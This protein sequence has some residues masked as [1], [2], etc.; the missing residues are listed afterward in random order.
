MQRDIHHKWFLPHSPETV[1]QFL[2]ESELLGQWLMKNDFRPVVG[3]QFNFHT[4]P[5]PGF[6]GTVYCQ[7]LEVVPG[8]RL[9]YSWKGGPRK[10]KITLDSV[11][12][13]TLVPKDKG[14]ELALEHAGFKGLKNLLAY[15]IMGK[16][17]EKII[18]R[19]SQK[20]MKE[21][22]HENI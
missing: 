1:W 10:G 21:P 8:K 22:S 14:T 17:W 11:V 13:W 20:H 18:H 4:K 3:H 7:V 9:S 6:D 16:G 2:T 19:L 12:T 15:V 5:R